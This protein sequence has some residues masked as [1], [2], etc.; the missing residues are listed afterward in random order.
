MKFFIAVLFFCQD[1]QCF[2]WKSADLFYSEEQCIKV[3]AAGSKE[4]ESNGIE[5]KG[6]CMQINTGKNI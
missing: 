1:E 3:L 5:S 2:F 4:L 6:T